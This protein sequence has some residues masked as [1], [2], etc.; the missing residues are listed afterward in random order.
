M[1]NKINPKATNLVWL[2]LE[3]TGLDP[4]SDRIIELA[5]VVTDK[6]LN[7]VAE[8]P[9]YA[10]HQPDEVLAGMDNWNVSQHTK[11][12][13]VERVKASKITEDIAQAEMIEFLMHHVPPMKSPMCGNTICQDRRFLARYMPKLQQ[14]FHYRNLDVS[15]LK[16]L[17]KHW[18]PS[19]F[20]G[21]KKQSRHLAL[22]DVYD[23]ID[24]MKYY[25]ENFIK[26]P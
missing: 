7:V 25:R 13:L 19:V 26:L 1:T 9:V 18:A 4:D 11:S 8:A 22:S 24:E 14:Y 20:N 10:I 12:G 6:E 17:A 23:S 2:D 3:M 15:T 16:I 21:L 5:V